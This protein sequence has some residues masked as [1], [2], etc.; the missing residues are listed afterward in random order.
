MF[1]RP[2][3]VTNH[4]YRL[5]VAEQLAQIGVEADI[6]ALAGEPRFQVG[7]RSPA[8]HLLSIA[9]ADPVVVALAAGHVVNDPAAFTKACGLAGGAAESDRIVTFGVRPVKMTTI[10]RNLQRQ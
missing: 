4:Q 9:L 10:D 7:D 1:G 6:F 2:I 5:M 3:V 8:R